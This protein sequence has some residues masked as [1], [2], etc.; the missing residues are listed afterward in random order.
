MLSKYLS[1]AAVA[2]TVGVFT[3]PVSAAPT[4][5]LHGAAPEAG[6]SAAE[7]VAYKHGVCQTN[8]ACREHASI[9]DQ[10]VHG[11]KHSG[12]FERAG[13]SLSMKLNPKQ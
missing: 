7:Q 12:N 5:N 4:S 1:I 6:A 11:A 13:Q 3:T 2:L 8:G 9:G 10:S